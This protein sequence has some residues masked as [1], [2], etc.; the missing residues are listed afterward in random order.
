[1][2]RLPEIF[3][4]RY[5]HW[6]DMLTFVNAAR[7][8]FPEL[9]TLRELGRTPEDR[10]LLC[11]QVT[12]PG[13][14]PESKPAYLVQANVHAPEVAGTTASLH[15]LWHLL[16]GA[17]S[18]PDVGRLLRDITFYLVPRMNPD[19]AEYILTTGGPIRSRN[20]PR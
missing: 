6:D 19:G 11:V 7:Q 10:P 9:V 17:D 8:E 14:D 2:P 3:Y 12:G 20:F 13:A 5:Y 15:L 18:D 16:T 4:D 1:M